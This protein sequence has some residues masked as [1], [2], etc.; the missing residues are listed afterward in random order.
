MYVQFVRAVQTSRQLRDSLYA[1]DCL[2]AQRL[3]YRTCLAYILEERGQYHHALPLLRECLVL[4]RRCRPIDTANACYA[5]SRTLVKL[6]RVDEAEGVVAE[7]CSS[8]RL[9]EE[10]EQDRVKEGI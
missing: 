5:V 4:G 9:W 2:S 7:G 8:L 3:L 6:K 1:D 10:E